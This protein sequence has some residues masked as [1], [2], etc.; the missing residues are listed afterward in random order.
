MC[1]IHHKLFDLGAFTLNTDM[2][3]LVSE[4]VSGGQHLALLLV[5]YHGQRITDAVQRENRP[6][7][8]YVSWH[9]DQVFK[10]RPIPSSEEPN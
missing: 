8:K 7:F 2:K 5:A 3:I 1:A 10:E 9:R 4:R 6:D